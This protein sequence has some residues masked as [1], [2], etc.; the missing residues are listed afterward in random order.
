MKRILSFTIACGIALGLMLLLTAGRAQA[1][2]LHIKVKA[3]VSSPFLVVHPPHPIIAP[4]RIT[5]LVRAPEGP[6]RVRIFGHYHPDHFIVVGPRA[7]HVFV[8]AHVVEPVLVGPRVIVAAPAPP[9]V[10]VEGPSVGIGVGVG[11]RWKGGKHRGHHHR[12]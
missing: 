3:E 2:T 8:R 6:P 7:P 5:M 4:T 12:H 10:I 9:A 11:G 1:E